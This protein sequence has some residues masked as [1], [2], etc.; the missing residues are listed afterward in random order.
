MLDVIDEVINKM[1]IVKKVNG[2]YV[3]DS[4]GKFSLRKVINA[5]F[6]VNAFEPITMNDYMSYASL[7]C[8]ENISPINSLEYDS[9]FC[10]RLKCEPK[11]SIQELEAKLDKVLELIE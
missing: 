5:L 9:Q 3:K 6:Q 1:R 2:Y 11:T 10:C 7:V 4:I 8:F